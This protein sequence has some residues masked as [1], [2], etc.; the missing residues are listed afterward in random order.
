[1]YIWLLDFIYKIKC[2]AANTDILL[3]SVT[4]QIEAV[5]AFIADHMHAKH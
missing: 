3:T 5:I 4:L 2:M 1:M